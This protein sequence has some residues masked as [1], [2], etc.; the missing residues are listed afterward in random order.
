MWIRMFGSIGITD[1]HGSE[2][3]VGG[4]KQRTVLGLL[5]LEPGQPVSGD[6][7][8][9]AL[10]GD[11]V[12]DRASRSLSTYVSNLRR[13]LGDVIVSGA[14]AYTLHVDRSHV[15]I[16]A[17]A[18]TVAAAGL[19]DGDEA[20]FQYRTALSMWGGAPFEGLDGFGAFEV[21]AQQLDE[22][23]L[24]AERAVAESDIASGDAASV[25]R[26]VD[27]LVREYPF[28]E[29]L[30]GL[31][32]RALYGAGRQV[33]ALES[34]NSFKIHLAEELGLDPSQ[35]LQD[36]ELQIL[37]QDETLASTRQEPSSMSPEEG[38]PVPFPGFLTRGHSGELIGREEALHQ[39]DTVY[40]SASDK[41]RVIA[42]IGEPGIG[43]T[44]LTSTW[45]AHNV[46]DGAMIVAGRCT[47]DA[48]LSYRPFIEI[49]KVVL[50]AQPYRIR[51]V[52]PA[53]GNLALL[54]P[55][56]GDAK[57]LPAPIQADPDTVE[58]LMAEAFAALLKPI[59]GD[60]ATITILEDLHWAD[61]QSIAVLAHL[62]RRTEDLP[63]L[64]IAN[65][66][67]T[68]L[69]SDHPLP[70]LLTDLRRERQL[71]RVLLDRL[72]RGEVK[73]MI[74]AHFGVDAS[75]SIVTSIAEETRGNP[76]F[77]E[78]LTRH[79]QDERALDIDG[80][81][82]SEIPIE[83][84]GIPEGLRDVIGRRVKRL[85]S[86][87][88]DL[89]KVAAVMG[90]G[91][92]IDMA[93]TI[94]GLDEDQIDAVA[95]VALAASI[96]NNDSS[97]GEFVFAHALVRQTI[98]EEL[99]ARRRVRLHRE[100][101]EAIEQSDEPTGALHH[102]LAANQPDKA[103][104][105]AIR[106]ADAGRSI[107]ANLRARK[108]LELALDLWEDVDDPETFIGLSHAD[109]VLLLATS[110]ASFTIEGN[111][112]T[113]RIGIELVRH[114]L[115]STEAINNA[116]LG[117]LHSELALLL[118]Y[119]AQHEEG[120][121]HAFLAVDLV[122]PEPPSVDRSTVLAN[123]ARSLF[124][125]SRASE[126]VEFGLEAL[127]MARAIG[128]DQVRA[129]AVTAL[130]TA[131]GLLGKVREADTYF[132]ELRSLATRS[133]RV[134]D[135]FIVY[136]N[137]GEMK[138][139]AGELEE[140]LTL[141][142][143]GADAAVEF[144]LHGFENFLRSNAAMI[145]FELGRWDEAAERIESLD[146]LGGLTSVEI[147][148]QM[149]RATIGAERGTYNG[150][151][152]ERRFFDDARIATLHPQNSG[153]AWSAFISDWRWR[154]DFA[155]AFSASNIAY[156]VHEQLDE[157]R[158]SIWVRA[159][160]IELIAD[161]MVDGIGDATWLEL[162]QRWYDRFIGMNPTTYATL[163]LQATSTADLARAKG[164]NSAALWRDA[165]DAWDEGSYL[166]AKARWR[167]AEALIET[168]PDH[169]DIESNLDLS[170]DV[171]QGLGA[172][173]LL[174][175]IEATRDASG[176]DPAPPGRR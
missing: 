124:L 149:T 8:I 71:D 32:M 136:V 57:D 96:L 19:V 33:E 138:R 100:V 27:A 104:A 91:F 170:Q 44:R 11:E 163:P 156:A 105:A 155:E 153:P 90:P 82:N 17:F 168:D 125:A 50:A 41:T 62:V 59:P 133:G 38:S 161:A 29:G 63:L 174:S 46:D 146:A 12:P 18:D 45:A 148:R 165:I 121:E 160:S 134:R 99:S 36:L 9:R 130:A 93:G 51:D 126:S 139:F 135:H 129:N 39:L 143:E 171:A 56:V 95:D 73:A 117:R 169:S 48:A 35:Q 152:T 166:Q 15:D 110:Y 114:E 162:A 69:V 88:S 6:Q 119:G 150:L 55:G 81:W 5:S 79:L 101:G 10:W 64:I 167:L 68:D 84:F 25:V 164:E 80:Q 42:V 123:L 157:S 158:D 109:L 22:L 13:E 144:G 140:A 107:S 21:E 137:Q 102:W 172:Q 120:M 159:H 131:L 132:D 75:D 34:F 127:E 89:L 66:R 176:P 28:D 14:G 4:P 43:K 111:A 70:G 77:I 31:H 86:D 103:L 141:S 26:R 76:F 87:A 58:Y 74:S 67:D 94:A 47:P 23:R 1:E 40:A 151:A 61:P 72:S 2:R 173:P 20:T 16:C 60:P 53:A 7:L 24:V 175:A 65:Y 145:A 49:A 52:G 85:G 115:A 108:D 54:V 97:T 30:R 116:T 142:D 3:P 92:S 118:L 128:S 147:N 106:S 154:S 98:Y 37:Q 113:T 83:Q 112:D 122:P 78:E